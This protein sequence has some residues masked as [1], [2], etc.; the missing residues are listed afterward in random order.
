MASN[1]S[2]A[3]VDGSVVKNSLS[4]H[5]QALNNWRS[6]FSDLPAGEADGLEK[7]ALEKL[8]AEENRR[9]EVEQSK[10]AAIKAAIDKA[11]AEQA[12]AA[13]KRSSDFV[14]ALDYKKAIPE[15]EEA[16]K[17]APGNAQYQNALT[18]TKTKLRQTERDKQIARIPCIII[19]AV[20]A[21][22]AI[23]LV[24][25]NWYGGSLG[26]SILLLGLAVFGITL[27]LLALL[28]ITKLF[29]VGFIVGG[30]VGIGLT[31]VAAY[32]EEPEI[33]EIILMAMVLGVVGVISGFISSF[34][35]GIMMTHWVVS[36]IA[37]S[38]FAIGIVAYGPA[39]IFEA[40]TVVTNTLNG[41]TKAA[42]IAAERA[43]AEQRIVELTEAIGLNPNDADAYRR[44]GGAYNLLGDYEHA[45]EDLTAYISLG[46]N[47]LEK[48]FTYERVARIYLNLGQFDSATEAYNAAFQ[49]APNKKAHSKNIKAVEKARKK[50]NK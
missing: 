29:K 13:Y 18:Q 30:I 24:I 31:I 26:K 35:A 23:N 38:A 20:L 7:K 14:K 47:D 36:A 25:A 37:M 44:R 43:E 32:L 40:G 6:S 42:E 2:Y 16:L 19:G 3:M 5:S 9:R 11:V 48:R 46:P 45:I 17:L 50:A 15:F 34:I 39:K 33:E 27:A 12:A 1:K 10:A 8:I 22:V 28:G 41:S 49:S 21:L 4:E